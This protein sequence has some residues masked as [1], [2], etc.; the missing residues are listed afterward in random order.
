M[1]QDDALRKQESGGKGAG[2]ACRAR[3]RRATSTVDI[4]PMG[5]GFRLSSSVALP[6][7]IGEVFAFFADAGNLDSITPSWL[8]FRIL[9]PMPVTMREG[10]RLDYRLRLRRIPI[11]WQSEITVWEPPYLFVDEQRKGPYRYW[12]HRHRFAAIDGGT[13]VFDEVDYAVP[14]GRLL[15]ERVVAPDLR[16]IFRFRQEKLPEL[17]GPG[18]R[19]EIDT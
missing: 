13:K 18:D 16:A 19:R 4:R 3:E 6:C 8:Q 17:F 1:F 14:G 5:K 11:H 12:I 9:T 7:P 15:N 10:L 2:G